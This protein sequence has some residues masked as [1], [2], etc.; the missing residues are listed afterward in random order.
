MN[1]STLSK[2]NR[3]AVRVIAWCITRLPSRDL[4]EHI[5]Q[6]LVIGTRHKRAVEV[7]NILYEEAQRNGRPDT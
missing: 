5:T 4:S 3:V 2:R 7:W 1:L 6:A